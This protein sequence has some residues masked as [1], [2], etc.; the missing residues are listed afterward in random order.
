M[1]TVGAARAGFLLARTR[2]AKSGQG[3]VEQGQE[4]VRS[5]DKLISEFPAIALS[6]AWAA[7]TCIRTNPQRSQRRIRT[8]LGEPQL[9]PVMRQ[10]PIGTDAEL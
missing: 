10:M 9:P 4:L 1:E 3:S 5:E 2:A 6:R 7:A 8:V